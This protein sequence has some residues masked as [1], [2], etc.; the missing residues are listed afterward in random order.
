MFQDQNKRIAL[1]TLCNGLYLLP[2]PPKHSICSATTQNSQ[3]L[4]WHSRIGHSSFPSCYSTS[5]LLEQL[6]ANNAFLHGDLYEEV[7]MRV[8]Q[9]YV[10]SLP[11]NTVCKLN[12]T[13]YGLKQANRQWFTK[14]TDFLTSINFHQSYAD[15]S[16][17]TLTQNGHT[18]ILL[19]YVND[20]ILTGDSPSLVEFI[21]QQHHNKFSIKDLG[22]VHYYLGIEFLR[23]KSGMV[24]SQRKYALELLQNAG[25]L[26]EKPT[27]VPLD[28][29][30]QLN[31]KD[32]DLLPD[33]SLYRTIVRKFI[34]L[35]FTRLNLSFIAQLLSQFS[36]QTRT[37]HM[38]ALLKVLGYIKL[39][40]GQGLHFPTQNSLQQKAFC[41]SDWASCPVTRRLVTRYAI[42]LGPC[43]IS[44]LS[45]KQPVVSRSSTEA[46][47]RALADC[48]CELTWLL[49]LF[50]GLK[51][52]IPTPVNI[53][54]DNESAIALAS[55]P[56][57]H[58]RTKRI[59][60]DYHFVREKIKSNHIIP[61]YIPTKYQAADVLTKGLPKFCTTI[62]YPS[63]ASV[64]LS[65]C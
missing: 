51:V 16:L 10:T 5:K 53:L 55:N 32:G 8:L 47:Y 19:V 30:K 61:S 48:T 45:K 25:V 44:W 1:G 4:L 15:T 57:Q 2:T 31:D 11:S 59:E 20:I 23:N 54:C 50:K 17:F 58:A 49:C 52:N 43:L 34:Y 36:N 26:E 24:I 9:G 40:P 42:F 14:L 12:K 33:P 60:L 65:H 38:K 46:E 7:Y 62:V 18:T 41:D 6:D 13:L 37:P 63:L 56:V 27:I 22:A 64:I 28:P 35:T 3:S 39:Y 21:K 29:A